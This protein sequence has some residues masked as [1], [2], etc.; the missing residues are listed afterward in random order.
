[1]QILQ[2]DTNTESNKYNKYQTEK[3]LFKE[4]ETENSYN[5]YFLSQEKIKLTA[6][7]LVWHIISF[8]CP[9]YVPN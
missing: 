6:C 7:K 8:L 3:E 1:M 9:E 2:N 4:T 5:S